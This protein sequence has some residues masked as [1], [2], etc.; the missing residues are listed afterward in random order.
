[1]SGAS[2]AAK[3]YPALAAKLGLSRREAGKGGSGALSGEFDG[4]RVFVDPDERPRIVVY[5]LAEPQIVLRTYEHEKRA[6]AG[7]VAVNPRGVPS[8]SLRDVYAAAAI[9]PV[10]AA[11]GEEL[12]KLLRPFAERWPRMVSHLSI[13]SER[14]ECALDFGRP[15]HIPPDVVELLLP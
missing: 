2:R 8:G 7:M 4:Y 5:A 6:P 11:R 10:L 13:T 1:R 15:S 12:G 3:E 9:G 14:L